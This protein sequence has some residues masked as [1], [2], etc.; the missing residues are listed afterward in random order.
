M[1]DSLKQRRVYRNVDIAQL[2]GYRLPPSGVVSILHRISGAVMFLLLPFVIWMF[3]T[4]ISSEVSF[5]RFT[6]VFNSGV[7]GIPGFMF[8]LVALLLI[9]SFLHHLI[10]GVR[11]LYMDLTHATDLK[12]ARTTALATLA[13]SLLLTVVLGY[14]LFF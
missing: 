8:K 10:A 13:S 5:D 1:A 12:F 2:G 7:F 3:D 4:S 9:W 14:K 11:H 6:S